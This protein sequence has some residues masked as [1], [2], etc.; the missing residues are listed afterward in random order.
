MKI[1]FIVPYVPTLVR[2]RP[3]NLIK[4]LS[5]L[6][7]DV[8]VL[9]ISS[10]ISDKDA[11]E[12]LKECGC[13]VDVIRLTKFRSFRNCISAFLRSEPLQASY[14]WHPEFAQNAWNLVNSHSNKPGF[15]IVHV[16][17][18]RGVRYALHL[19]SLGVD[20]PILW[21]SVDCISLLF[22]QTI[23]K[24]ARLFNRLIAKVELPR[25]ERFEAFATKQVDRTIVTSILDRS[26][27]L[28]LTNSKKPKQ[29]DILPNGV[30]LDY[31]KPDPAVRI[32]PDTLI[33]SGKMSYHANISM[34]SNLVN[35][36]MPLI[37]DHRP[38]TQ[39]CIVGKDPPR[40]V[41]KLAD[42]ENIQVTGTVMDIRPYIQKAMVALAPL[43][44]GAGIQN[45]VL[46][47]MACG[48]PVVASSKAIAAIDVV[49]GRDILVADDPQ[50]YAK[51]VIRVLE[52]SEYRYK[53]S[54][55]GRSYV[56][57][58]HDWERIVQRLVKIYHDVCSDHEL[59]TVRQ[60][61]V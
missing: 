45:K 47:A 32:E 18:L 49:K 13:K 26:A 59:Q 42:H 37:W 53:I 28:S 4:Y 11:V 27:L 46:E 58:F 31:F 22:R 51:L 61:V 16:E 60:E 55:F 14:C 35:N 56:V 2:V 6:G 8:N 7:H 9:A 29:I 44:Y 3:Y 25:T 1:L 12:Y 54:E 39:L 57:Q 30:D 50:E 34:V 52:D 33:V 40:L 19:K 24:S 21:D 17:H 5:S 36:I 23:P 15:D 41:N 20:I 38:K 43:T 10:D 48:T